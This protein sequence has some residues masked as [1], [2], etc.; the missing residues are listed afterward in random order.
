MIEATDYLIHKDN[1][2]DT[3]KFSVLGGEIVLVTETFAGRSKDRVKLCNIITA[4]WASVSSIHSSGFVV[5]FEN[6]LL[7]VFVIFK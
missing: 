7:Y 2:H 4:N 6:V 3:V 1:F 5:W